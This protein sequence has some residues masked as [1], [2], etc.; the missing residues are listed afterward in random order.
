MSFLVRKISRA[1][2]SPSNINDNPFDIPS[3]TIT[4]DLKSTTNTLSVW[5]VL[6]VSSIDE[7]VLAIVSS[8]DRIDT[9]DIVWIPKNE[10]VSKKIDCISTPG[11]TPITSL[12]NNHVDLSNLTY[13]K[14]GLFA[15]SI[16]N[17]ISSS[18]IKRYNKSA[19]KKLFNSSIQNGVFAKTD[20][21][22]RMQEDL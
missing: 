4:K 10:L 12:I 22:L 5:E 11:A 14:I 20:L 3:D 7:A 2:W 17:N 15:E 9:I 19:L 13:F 18:N 6:N 16:M 21:P 1:K 8:G